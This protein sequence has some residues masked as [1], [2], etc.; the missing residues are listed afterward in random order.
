VF[1]TLVATLLGV[2]LAL[3]NTLNT[4]DGGKLLGGLDP[5]WQFV[6]LLAVPPVLVGLTTYRAAVG[7]VALGPGR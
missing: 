3:V 5:F 6:I 2:A 7:R 4:P 1:G